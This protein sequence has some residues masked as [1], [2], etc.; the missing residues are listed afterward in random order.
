MTKKIL[1]ADQSEAVRG[2]AENVL[3]RNGFEVVSANDGLEASDLLRSADLDLVFLNSTLPELDGYALSRQIKSEFKTKKVKVVLLLSTSEIVNQRQLMSSQADDT[4]N[5]PFSPQDLLEK[6]GALLGIDLS[7]GSQDQPKEDQLSEDIEELELGES[8]ED[9]IDFGSIFE[10]EKKAGSDDG[11]DDVFLAAE[12]RHSDVEDEE[13][14]PEDSMS[15]DIAP[16]S[17]PVE[18]AEDDHDE[19]SI[20]LAD[21]QFGLEEPF[22]ETEINSPHDYNWFIREMKKDLSDDGDKP[23][24]TSAKPKK[25][26]KRAKAKPGVPVKQESTAAGTFA[27]EELGSSKIDLSVVPESSRHASTSPAASSATEPLDQRELSLAEKLL[28]KEVSRQIAE[29]VAER[30]STSELR[31]IVRDI[32]QNLRNL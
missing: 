10:S 18:P 16:D 13:S 26:S 6:C 30:L 25:K 7:D 14:L 21:D 17:E 1:I 2:V 4:L 9:E 15:M 28:I 31:T 27:V 11:L 32:L 8:V 5:K 23:A 20:R 3:R 19:S 22:P 24:E 29:K 12:E